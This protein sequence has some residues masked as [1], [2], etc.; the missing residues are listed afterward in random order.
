[1]NSNFV[2]EQSSDR[3]SG[4]S[5]RRENSD[6]ESEQSSG[7]DR[8]QR[9]PVS[10]NYPS[11]SRHEGKKDRYSHDDLGLEI[12]QEPPPKVNLIRT[13]SPRAASKVSPRPRIIVAGSP[14]GRTWASYRNGRHSRSRG[15]R[16]TH[17]FGSDKFHYSRM[18]GD[19]LSPEVALS[20]FI[21][22]EDLGACSCKL[23][24]LSGP[25]LDKNRDA[26]SQC[27]L[28]TSHRI[29]WLTAQEL[30]C[31]QCTFKWQSDCLVYGGHCSHWIFESI[32]R[33][34]DNE[35]KNEQQ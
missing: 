2:T 23:G 16:H 3:S 28:D 26:P 10:G 13:P 21:R 32:E 12:K 33:I 22:R 9:R 15:S 1:M 25:L 17:G 31:T 24:T 11:L 7:R 5:R 20:G 34:K 29:K 30:C 27:H 14:T 35:S 8:N 18:K 4:N 6:F 19:S